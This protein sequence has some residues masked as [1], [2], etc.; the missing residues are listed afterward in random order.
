MKGEVEATRREGGV[1]LF[2]FPSLRRT[3]NTKLGSSMV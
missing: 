3:E 1:G 2:G